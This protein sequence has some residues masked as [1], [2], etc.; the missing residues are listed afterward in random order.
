MMDL[1]YVAASIAF[2]A[3]SAALVVAFERL[4]KL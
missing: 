2:F 3:L 4:R 1:V